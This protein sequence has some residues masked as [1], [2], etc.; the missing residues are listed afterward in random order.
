MKNTHAIDL[1]KSSRGRRLVRLLVAAACFIVLAW[2]GVN[3][4]F[5][6]HQLLHKQADLNARS[7]IKQFT[8]NAAKPMAEDDLTQLETLREHLELDDNVLSITI[9]DQHGT[10]V[11]QGR[12]VVDSDNIHGLPTDVAGISKLKTPIV[13][14]IIFEGQPLGFASMIYLTKS[15]MSQSHYH[16]HELGRM[17]LVMLLITCVFTWQ[18]GRAL[19][20]WEVKRQIRKSVQEDE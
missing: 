5:E 16:F 8:L 20:G 9:Y 3:T 10:L 11:L 12:N 14:P 4:S 18:I 2:L 7:L 6:S 17:V 15:A 13:E 1:L 19:K